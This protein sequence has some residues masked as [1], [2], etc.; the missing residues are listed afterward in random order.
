MRRTPLHFVQFCT[1]IACRRRGAFRARTVGSV[2][3][4]P[5]VLVREEIAEAGVDLLRSRFD[6]DVDGDS[7][8]ASIIGIATTRS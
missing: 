8:L 3:A 4:R 2:N 6:V 1:W 5:R 7:D